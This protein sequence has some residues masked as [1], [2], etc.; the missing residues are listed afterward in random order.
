[1]SDAE[2]ALRGKSPENEL[3]KMASKKVSETMVH[4]SDVRPST[5]YKKPVVEALFIRAVRKALDEEA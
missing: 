4:W 3:L 2:D 5:P 1:M